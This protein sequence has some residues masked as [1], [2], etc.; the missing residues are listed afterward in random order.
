[1]RV[2]TYV[3]RL[4]TAIMALLGIACFYWMSEPTIAQTTHSSTIADILQAY[5]QDAL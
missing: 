1:M 3:E 5:L 2:S 4:L